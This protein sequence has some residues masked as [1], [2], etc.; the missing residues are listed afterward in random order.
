MSAPIGFLIKKALSAIFMPL[1]ICLLFFALGGAYV[2]LRRSRDAL[3]PFAIGAMLLYAF[4][5]NSISGYL[6]RPL[7]QAYAPLD[8]TVLGPAGKTVKWVVVLGSWHWT[9]RRLSAAGMLNESA[10]SRL[11]E[12]IRVAKRLSGSVL[13]V[14]GGKYRDEQ[15]SAHVM[16]SAAVELGFDPACILLE[17]TSLDTED[18]AVLIKNMVGD[19]P[20]V[21]V[22]SASHM[23]RSMKLFQG[24]GMRPIPAP[25]YFRNKGEPETF[26]PYPDNILTCHLAVHEYL[27]LAWALVRGKISLD[28]P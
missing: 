17:D 12:G 19:E 8:V 16:A 7:E 5:L 4:S 9:D 25:A 14:S 1:S 24:Q 26:V 20:F 2:L 22:T 27:G 10:L 28:S 3:A 21:L 15:S 11:V 18:E 23:L 6:V 13:L